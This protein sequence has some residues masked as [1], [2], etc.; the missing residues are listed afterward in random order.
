VGPSPRIGTIA[1]DLSRANTWTGQQIVQG[2]DNT[3][4]TAFKVINQANSQL[5]SAVDN[6]AVSMSGTLSVGTNGAT[7]AGSTAGSITVFNAG[8]GFFKLI[9]QAGSTQTSTITVV[10]TQSTDQV[11]MLGTAQTFSAATTFSG[12][13]MFNG[14]VKI[15]SGHL[16]GIAI[17][18][19]VTSG[20]ATLDANASDL[21]GTVTEGTAQTGFTLTFHAA[22]GTVPHCVISSPN[23]ATFTSYT[24]A[25][26]TLAVANLSATGSVFTYI[27]TQ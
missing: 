27:C 14:A 17:G 5:L 3:G 7:P 11:A 22:Y 13:N 4:T 8:T 21:S 16:G 19:T 10:S 1:L 2:P 12:T 23:G 6:G 26:T 18:P 9:P 25:T 15:G 24:P 20:T